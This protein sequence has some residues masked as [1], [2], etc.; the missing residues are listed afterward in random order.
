MP[1]DRTL[2]IVHFLVV[3]IAQMR[4]GVVLNQFGKRVRSL[5][6]AVGVL[7]EHLEEIAFTRQ[8][9]AKK[10]GLLLMRMCQGDD[11]F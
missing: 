5:H 1:G 4:V 6:D 8:Q 9:L 7:V 10:H 11:G 2:R 3:L